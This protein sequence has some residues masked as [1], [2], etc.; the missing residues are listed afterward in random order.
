LRAGVVE[1][2]EQR[3]RAGERFGGGLDFQGGVAGDEFHAERAFGV[4]EIV[5]ATRVKRVEVTGRRE[6]QRFRRQGEG[7]KGLKG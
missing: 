6:M 5:V 2:T 4:E 1:Q 3:L 7:K